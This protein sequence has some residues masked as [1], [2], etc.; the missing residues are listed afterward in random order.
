MPP[1]HTM[2]RMS[3]GPQENWLGVAG[4]GLFGVELGLDVQQR[5]GPNSYTR[6]AGVVGSLR[7]FVDISWIP[8]RLGDIGKID[9]NG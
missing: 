2:P 5:T 6:C 3:I 1:S 9:V 4:A 8:W 7:G